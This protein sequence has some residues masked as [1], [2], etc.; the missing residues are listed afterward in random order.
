MFT[1]R[2]VDG[3]VE[4]LVHAQPKASRNSIVGKHGD[5][6]KIAVTAAPSDGKANR[7]IIDL[8]ADA[9]HVKRSEVE[10]SAGHASR[11]KTILIRGLSSGQASKRVAYLLAGLQRRRNR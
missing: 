10:V 4:F 3:G 9:F 2:A 6:L 1:L 8:V 5:R 11:D 7:A